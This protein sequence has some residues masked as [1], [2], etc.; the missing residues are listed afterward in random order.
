MEFGAEKYFTDRRSANTI[1]LF[2]ALKGY[3]LVYSFF[4]ASL[5]V[6]EFP[7][8]YVINVVTCLFARH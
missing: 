8:D 1:R 4:G 6:G 3:F 7:R 5:S 2:V